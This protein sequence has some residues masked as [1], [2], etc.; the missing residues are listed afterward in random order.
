MGSTMMPPE[1]L[2]QVKVALEHLYDPVALRGSAMGPELLPGW[3]S[4]GFDRA[5]A[6]RQELLDA[7]EQ[8]RPARPTPVDVHQSRAYQIL[9]LRYVEGLPFRDVMSNL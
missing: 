9:Q 7:V 5:R 8:L 3:S 6:L 1:F 2:D 4:T